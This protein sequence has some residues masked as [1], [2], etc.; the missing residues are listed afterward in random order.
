MDRKRIFAAVSA[1][2]VGITAFILGGGSSQSVFGA[3]V[4]A[5]KQAAFMTAGIRLPEKGGK[6]NTQQEQAVQPGEL[7]GDGSDSCGEE[8]EQALQTREISR[9]VAGSGEVSGEAE[10]AATEE[11]SEQPEEARVISCNITPFDDELDYTAAG[12]KSGTIYRKHYTG[13]SGDDYITLPGG[14]LIWNC[15]SDSGG[16]IAEAIKEMPD[17]AIEMDSAE[18]QVMIVHTHTTESY[19]PYQRSYYDAKFPFRTRDPEHNMVRVGEVLAQRLAENGISVLHDGSVHD[20]PAYTGAYDRSEATIRAALEE[21]PSIKVIIDLHRDAISNPDGSRTAPTAVINGRNA[22]QFMIIT[23]CD[24]G[25]FGNMPEYL[26]NL[27]LACLIQE[28]AEQL[29]PGLARPILFDYRNYNQHISTGSLL[30][31]VGSHANSLDEAMYTA[32]LLGDSI[33]KALEQ[34]TWSDE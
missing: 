19:E 7:N 14:G 20:Y 33:A 22:A 4:G 26:E 10:T 23:G 31:E 21:Y 3:A 2:A 18:P 30:I 25:R 27:R 11:S 16:V 28:S 32:E 29:Y 15:T 6:E 9:F 8:M 24:D 12:E 17:I 34:L 5:A 13:Y 1:A